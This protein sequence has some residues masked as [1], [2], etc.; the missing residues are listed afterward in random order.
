MIKIALYGALIGGISLS[1]QD[2]DALRQKLMD[3]AK[4]HLIS[5][6]MINGRTVKG[7]PYSAQ[8]TNE[9]MQLLADGNRITNSNSSMLYRDSLGR[10]RREESFSAGSAQASKSIF[11][12]DPVEGVS[13][14]LQTGS[15]VARKGA[16]SF[17]AFT[18]AG[19]AADDGV[20]VGI[21]VG[22]GHGGNLSETRTV[23]INT[24]GNSTVET[25]NFSNRGNSTKDDRKEENLG[26]QVIEG[27][28]AEGTR[29]TTTIAAGTIGNEQPIVTVNER[30][31][32]PELQVLVMSMRSDPRS[33][34]TTY[35]LTNINRSEPPP[36][37]FQVPA[38]YTV[39]DM[40]RGG[41]VVLKEMPEEQQ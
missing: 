33:G 5:S 1:A 26:M 23:V 30:W 8:S 6:Q 28:S 20:N 40:T 39:T 35:K 27:V 12:S 16:Q 41:R 2:V 17:F 15:K 22:V 21:G 9:T 10:E 36:A 32:S 3:E 13:Y 34:T 29:I 25:I 24:S 7:A 14:T 19:R 4:A 31:Y 37:L 11:I 38:D 18:T